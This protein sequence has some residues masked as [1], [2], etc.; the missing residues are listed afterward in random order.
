M[1]ES[2]MK[3]MSWVRPTKDLPGPPPP[4]LMQA[5]AER[6]QESFANGTMIDTGGLATMADSGAR[7]ELR[8]GKVTVL[9][10]PFTEAKELAGGYA[11]LNLDSLDEAIE[12]AQWF[13]GIHA[14]HWPEWEGEVEVRAMYSIADMGAP[15]A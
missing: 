10:G 15:P 2:D 8:G 14:E 3:Y 9:D 6:Q 13:L 7:L 12:V 1:K 11:I 5:M 4:G